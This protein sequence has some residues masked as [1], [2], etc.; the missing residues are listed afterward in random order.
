MEQQ[1]TSEIGANIITVDRDLRKIIYT[2]RGQQVMLDSDLAELYSAETSRLNQAVKRN[3]QR[4]PENFRFQ[5]TRDEYDVLI[6]QIVISKTDVDSR[7]GR[8]KLPFVFTE[9]GVAMLSAVLRSETAINVSIRIMESFV[10]MRR[11][12]ADTSSIHKR[13]SSIEAHQQKTD[14]KIEKIF[15]Q[16]DEQKDSEHRIFYKGQMYDAFSALVEIIEAAEDEIILLDN[17]VDVTTLNLLAKKKKQ[18]SVRIYTLNN[19]RLS[20]GD[21]SIFNSQYPAI[22]VNYTHD[23]H[24]RFLVI[25]G[26]MVYHIGASLKDAGKKS[27]A[28]NIISDSEVATE[29]LRRITAL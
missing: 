8:Q 22:E 4:F 12:M 23:F 2:V 15:E 9:Q 6:S 5:L 24:D 10:E 18:V 21:I 26:K 27:F 25:D 16:I 14:D 28:I 11:Y 19:T 3:L 17:Y 20:K 29:F 7:G 1:S 13:L